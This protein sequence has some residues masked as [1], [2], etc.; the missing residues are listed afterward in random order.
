MQQKNYRPDAD[1]TVGDVK[2]RPMVTA[3]V[4]VE[5]VDYLSEA[6]TVNQVTGSTPK[7]QGQRDFSP[8]IFFSQPPVD[9]DYH[10]DPDD[11]NGD[12]EHLAPAAEVAG[13]KAKRCT[14]ISDMN[15]IEEARDD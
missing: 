6:H 5:K 11:A 12:K 3:D 10:T 7:D 2:C 13:Q 14:R 9:I 8:F 15:Q 4:Y 1:R